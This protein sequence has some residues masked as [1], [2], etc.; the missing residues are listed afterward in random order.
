MRKIIRREGWGQ[1][2]RIRVEYGIGGRVR[3][4]LI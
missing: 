1:A 2:K 4:V 3:G